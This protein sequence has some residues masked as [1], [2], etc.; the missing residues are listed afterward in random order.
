MELD[1]T[2]TINENGRLSYII[3]NEKKEDVE[4]I[5]TDGEFSNIAY[6]NIDIDKAIGVLLPSLT[7][8]VVPI[9]GLS[10]ISDIYNDY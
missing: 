7:H 3:H 8:I 9:I 4:V 6:D 2:Q 5:R 10:W 1:M